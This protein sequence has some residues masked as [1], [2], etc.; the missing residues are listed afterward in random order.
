VTDLGIRAVSQ[1]DMAEY[2]YTHFHPSDTAGVLL[3]LDTTLCARG[4]RS[5]IVVAA[6]REGLAEAFT[7]GHDQRLVGG[8]D[9]A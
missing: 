5:Q 8:R 4:C 6:G 2:K 9:P 3:S 1:K 7:I